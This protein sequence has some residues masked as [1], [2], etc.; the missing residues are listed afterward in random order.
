MYRR[1]IL[2]DE[3]YDDVILYLYY[4]IYN[5]NIKREIHKKNYIINQIAINIMY[6]KKR[7]SVIEN[8]FRTFN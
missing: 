3:N 5:I 2:N 1:V 4:Y 7:D 6:S 8:V